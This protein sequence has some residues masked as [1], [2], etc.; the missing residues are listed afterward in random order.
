MSLRTVMVYRTN[1]KSTVKE[2]LGI[3][4]E[5]RKSERGE[6]IVGML[7]LARMEFAGAAD[8]TGG[9]FIG[10]YMAADREHGDEESVAWHDSLFLHKRDD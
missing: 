4:V 2:P 5:R 7:R 3:L 10:D 6:N 1:G 8:G 9:I